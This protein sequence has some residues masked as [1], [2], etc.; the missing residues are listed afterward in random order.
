M[1]S[2]SFPAPYNFRRKHHLILKSSSDF[3]RV[4]INNFLGRNIDNF[5]VFNAPVIH[6]TFK[7]PASGHK[8]VIR[9]KNNLYCTQFC[10]E[11]GSRI[12]G[13]WLFITL[14]IPDPVNA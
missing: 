11:R 9:L 3:I 4:R 7:T 8:T 12:I 6:Q 14:L 2:R 1:L 5:V 13:E 10:S